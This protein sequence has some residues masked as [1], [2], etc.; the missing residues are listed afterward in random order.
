M[1]LFAML[2]Y[3]HRNL[4][5]IYICGIQWF[6]IHM[7]RLC[8]LWF[9]CSFG[10][11]LA[12]LAESIQYHTFDTHDSERT[13]SVT[14]LDSMMYA[15]ICLHMCFISISL[16]ISVYV[17]KLRSTTSKLISTSKEKATQEKA[18]CMCHVQCENV[19]EP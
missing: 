14:T 13:L 15:A 4:P 3:R 18:A 16:V 12:I 6:W 8:P 2:L 11:I 7:V 9:I 17:V 1:T 10:N 19:A 5:K